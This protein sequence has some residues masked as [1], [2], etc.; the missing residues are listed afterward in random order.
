MLNRF[1]LSFLFICLMI[2]AVSHGT[3]AKIID[4]RPFLRGEVSPK[5][6]SEKLT[7]MG[8]ML[9]TSY[10]FMY[11][12][13]IFD[14]ALSF[15]PKNR[16]A[17]FYKHLVS[18]WTP[19]KGFF[20][21]VNPISDSYRGTNNYRTIQAEIARFGSGNL[22]RYLTENSDGLALI[23][24][25]SDFQKLAEIYQ[26]SLLDL[27]DFLASNMDMKFT[28][29]SP[30]LIRGPDDSP[31]QG[32]ILQGHSG[33]WH[34]CDVKVLGENVYDLNECPYL[35]IVPVDVDRVDLEIFRI[36]L[37]VEL[38]RTISGTSYQLDGYLK[39]NRER[40]REESPFSDQKYVQYFNSIPEF[41]RLKKN[42]KLQL[43]KNIGVDLH[44]ALSWLTYNTNQTCPEGGFRYDKSIRPNGYFGQAIYCFDQND[45]VESI[46]RPTITRISFGELLSSSWKILNG[47]SFYVGGRNEVDSSITTQA[48]LMPFLQNP[49]PNI[50]SLLPTEFS[51]CG[52]GTRVDENA[53]SILLPNRETTRF[54]TEI[55]RLGLK[56]ES[57]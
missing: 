57:K 11:A 15:D 14:L 24:S 19:F 54:L 29:I 33:L 56:C 1:R 26:K 53:W 36:L 8:E 32:R 20:A 44:S 16:K 3:P 22:F 41:G 27:R 10:S 9:L 18:V 50:K 38:L 51:S 37:S 23:K 2:C 42:Q 43:L 35:E 13:K 30:S 45:Q 46:D 28:M 21:R 47:G 4:I 17:Q 31:S 52:N 25:E 55:Q 39:I 12:E 6:R 40:H 34:R 7:E 5:Q 48:Q 49:S